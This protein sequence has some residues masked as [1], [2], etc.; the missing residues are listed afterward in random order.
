MESARATAPGERE[1]S[2]KEGAERPV[3]CVGGR[4][5][6]GSARVRGGGGVR[7]G[8]GEA[9]E[10]NA[11]ASLRRERAEAAGQGRRD[12]EAL[13]SETRDAGMARD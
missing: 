7:P 10:G 4:G 2:G 5:R 1:A 12:R 11:E 3:A 8:G 9:G 6:A 13:R